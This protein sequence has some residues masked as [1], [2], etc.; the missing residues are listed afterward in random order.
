MAYSPEKAFGVGDD[1][2][3]FVL[4]AEVSDPLLFTERRVCQYHHLQ[5]RGE[6]GGEGRGGEGRGGEGR[7]G[8]RR[9][10]EGRGGEGRRGEREGRGGEGRGGEERG[11]EVHSISLEVALVSQ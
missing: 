6:R 7:G 11:G 3:D 5:S 4:V 10:G 8:E 9:G 1:Y 2:F